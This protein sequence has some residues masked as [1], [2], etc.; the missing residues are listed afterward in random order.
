MIIFAGRQSYEFADLFTLI[1]PS[2]YVFY[3][4]MSKAIFYNKAAIKRDVNRKKQ[5]YNKGKKMK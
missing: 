2:V 5:N 1:M 4:K 3:I